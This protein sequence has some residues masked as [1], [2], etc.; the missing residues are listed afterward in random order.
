MCLKPS[1]SRNSTATF[2]VV[3]RRQ[4]DGLVDA[5]VQQHA[6]GQTGQKVVLGGMRHLHGHGTGRADVAEDDD[7]AG[8]LP[9]A[10][11]DGCHGVFDGNFRS[12]APNEDA[13]GRQVHR[14]VLP[15]RH[16]HRVRADFA[17]GGVQDAEY[18]G[19]GPAGCLCHDQPVI[20][21]AARLRKVMFPETSVHTTASPMQLR[22][23]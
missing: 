15:D 20:F 5:V 6:V 21:S 14:A 8:G 16:F 23:T 1:R 7:R 18:F 22:V 12:V 4:G 10:V 13:A 19:H 2:F 17:A 3:P 11:V 9:F